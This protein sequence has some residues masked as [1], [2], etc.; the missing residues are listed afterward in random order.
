LH[1]ISI[2]WNIFYMALVCVSFEGLC[3]LDF[4]SLSGDSSREAPGLA[5][6]TQVLGEGLSPQ[7]TVT[8]STTGSHDY[9]GRNRNFNWAC[10]WSS[11]WVLNV[12]PVTMSSIFDVGRGGRGGCGPEGQTLVLFIHCVILPFALALL[13][14]SALGLKSSYP[15]ESTLRSGCPRSDHFKKIYEI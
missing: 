9:K 14:Q 3:H 12:G 2:K 7:T 6:L 13:V 8:R 11:Y 4:R 10:F 5:F 15:A 1:F